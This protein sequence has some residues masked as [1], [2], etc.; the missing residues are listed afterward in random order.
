MG[1]L[2]AQGSME[3]HGNV[4]L[5]VSRVRPQAG[6]L[7]PLKEMLR[8]ALPLTSW[9]TEVREW[10]ARN[11]AHLLPGLWPWLWARKRGI[12]VWQPA[13]YLTKIDAL[14]RETDY[15]LVGLK[16]VTTAGVGF[17]VDAFQNSVELENLKFHAVGTG[18]TAEN[19]SDTGLETEW[20]SSEYTNR[21]TGTTTEGASANIYRTVAT[22]TKAN[23]GTS[24]LREH[25][26]LSSATIGAG[27]LL[28]RT[29]FAAITLSQ[30]DSLQSTYELTCS[31]GG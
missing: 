22:N 8:Q 15:G 21:A 1:L 20:T 31:S 7:M 4:Q 26:V 27:V 13:L 10:K 19:A 23:S 17:I 5:F 29:V 14:G 11:L 24:A 16:V 6:G 30:N 3:P 18:S 2:Q 9:P 28:D 12:L 25:G